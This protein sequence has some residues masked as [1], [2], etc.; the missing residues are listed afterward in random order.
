MK[1][2]VNIRRVLPAVVGV[3][4]VGFAGAEH[5]YRRTVEWHFWASEERHARLERQLTE[6]L[7][8]RYES[9]ARMQ[10]ERQR[11]R[12]LTDAL[13]QKT[14]QLND[15]V[16]RLAQQTQ[17]AR[18]LE[19]RLAAMEQQ[20]GRLQ[21]ELSLALQRVSGRQPGANQVQL[22][23]VIIG[24]EASQSGPR[25]RV[26]SIDENWNFVVFDLG[27]DTVKIGDTVSIVRNDRVLAKARVERVQ[28][29][30]AAAAILPDWQD[31]QIQVNDAVQVL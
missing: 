15:T 24:S 6:R 12:E 8:K 18:E 14:V 19:G 9:E 7:A 3:L 20:M 13:T 25:G 2:H 11:N 16:E 21:G 10:Q 23:R 22:E 30:V 26:V 31:A 29:D 17:M 27:W 4:L 1:T 5:L 28:E